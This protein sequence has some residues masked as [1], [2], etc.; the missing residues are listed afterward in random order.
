MSAHALWNLTPSPA[1]VIDAMR[2]NRERSEVI[3][4]GARARGEGIRAFS[5]AGG[6]LIGLRREPDREHVGLSPR[7]GREFS[8]FLVSDSLYV[9]CL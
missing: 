7:P 3:I 5:A 1:F 8:F 6:T 2:G 4:L 9:G